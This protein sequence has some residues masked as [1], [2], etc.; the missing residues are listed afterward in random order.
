[1]PLYLWF[2]GAAVGAAIA[3][4]NLSAYT[5]HRDGEWHRA[6]RRDRMRRLVGGRW[7]YRQMTEQE[8]DEENSELA[9]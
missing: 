2:L 1:M 8:R 7:Q 5:L 4:L 6:G 3:W 9:W